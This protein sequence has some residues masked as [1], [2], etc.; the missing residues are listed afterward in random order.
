MDG[1]RPSPTIWARPSKVGWIYYNSADLTSL[2][3]SFFFFTLVGLDSAHPSRL[4]WKGFSPTHVS[5]IFPFACKKYSRFGGVFEKKKE[6]KACLAEGEKRL[7]AVFLVVQGRPTCGW[8]RQ[9][10]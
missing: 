5:G 2:F 8:L 9:R 1:E 6:R 4:G 3:F 10:R 7:L